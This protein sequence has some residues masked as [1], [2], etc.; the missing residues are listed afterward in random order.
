MTRRELIGQGFLQ[1][2]AMVLGGGL[3]SLFANPRTAQA[4]L[5][6]DLQALLGACGINNVGTRIPF[7]CFD[8]AGGCNMTGSN[9]LVGKQG[10]QLDVLSTAGYSKLGLP[11]DMTPA[12]VTE[13]DRQRHRHQQRHHIDTSLGLRFHSD[14]AFLRGMYGSF[15]TPGIGANINRAGDPGPL[16]E[17]HGQQSAQPALRHPAHGRRRLDRHVDRH[18]EHRLGRQTDGAAQR[19]SIRSFSLRRST[20][21]AT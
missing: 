20:G 17:R 15:K 2:G 7:I 8:L 6:T 10:G 11:G 19:W 18:A 14:S 1:G 4:Q 3:L 13:S 16:R 9:V 12:V 21:R 5:A